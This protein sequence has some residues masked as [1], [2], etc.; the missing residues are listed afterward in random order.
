LGFA[1]SSSGAFK[2]IDHTIRMMVTI[3]AAKKLYA[4]QKGPDMDSFCHPGRKGPTLAMMGL[5]H[6]R[7]GFQLADQFIVGLRLLPRQINVENEQRIS[8]RWYIVW[9]RTYL[10]KVAAN[11]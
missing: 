10:P 9:C 2:V 5:C 11:P 1:G 4:Q 7:I 8:P 3:I 6:R